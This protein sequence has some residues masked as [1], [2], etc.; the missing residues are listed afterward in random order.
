VSLRFAFCFLQTE[1]HLTYFQ[2]VFGRDISKSM[3]V[4]N[5]S[6]IIIIIIITTTTTVPTRVALLKP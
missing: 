3:T 5:C 1:Q 4:L 6:V 2:V